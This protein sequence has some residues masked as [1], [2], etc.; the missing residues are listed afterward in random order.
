MPTERDRQTIIHLQGQEITNLISRIETQVT[1]IT[2]QESMIE[3][4]LQAIAQASIAIEKGTEALNEQ[5]QKIQ[6]LEAELRSLR[7]SEKSVD[8]MED[9]VLKMRHAMMNQEEIIARQ[10]T[11]ID[12]LVKRRREEKMKYMEGR[13]VVE[14]K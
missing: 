3:T 11:L 13:I 6:V 14:D 7:M 10:R 9:V 4:Q 8:V 1:I 5:K 2:R 12:H